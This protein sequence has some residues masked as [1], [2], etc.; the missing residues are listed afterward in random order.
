MIR[1]AVFVFCILLVALP[2]CAQSPNIHAN[3]QRMEDNIKALSRYGANPG[4][5]VSR[6]AYSDADIEGRAYIMDLIRD[7][8][9]TVRIDPAGNIIGH[10][11]GRDDDA[12][13]AGRH[14]TIHADPFP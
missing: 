1:R 14:R 12:R 10:R 8:G 7:V 11:E 2:C 5:G 9:L 3:P 4:G 6:V 13:A